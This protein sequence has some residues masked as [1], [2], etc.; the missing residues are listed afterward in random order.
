[1]PIQPKRTA[2]KTNPIQQEIMPPSQGEFLAGANVFCPLKSVFAIAVHF[3]VAIG[4]Q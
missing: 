1:M 4:L 3:A 2:N